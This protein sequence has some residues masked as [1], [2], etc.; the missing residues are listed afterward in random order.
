ME[1]LT[2]R[3]MVGLSF[4][5]GALVG[6]SVGFL[7]TKKA[8]KEYYEEIS[9]NEI[10]Q[11]REFYKALYHKPEP[12][13][14]VGHRVGDWAQPP[15][16]G[17][18]AEAANALKS[19][20]NQDPEVEKVVGEGTTIVTNIF[21]SRGQEVNVIED[22]WDQET[23]DRLRTEDAPYIL[24]A[25]EFRRNDKGYD[26]VAYTYYD[27]DGV[28]ADEKD[29]MI[30]NVDELVGDHNVTKFGHGSGDPTVLYVR[31]DVIQI[32]F[33]LAKN[34]GS[35]AEQVLGFEHS[36]DTYMKTRR[37]SRRDDE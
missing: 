20:G 30:P 36:G 5:G 26:Q 25:D 12:K 28:L 10:L 23:E 34:E 14:V 29:Q 8:L 9:N 32:E 37:R 7:A 15:D 31:N 13:D 24:S 6:A 16:Q 27:G 35:F 21:N 33:E 17:E 18:I 22:V 4:A 2:M 19:Y 11:A 1:Q 3:Q